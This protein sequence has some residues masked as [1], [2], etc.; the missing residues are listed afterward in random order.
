MLTGGELGTVAL[1]DL[2]PMR[3]SERGRG[4]EIQEGLIASHLVLCLWILVREY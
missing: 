2:H 4:K 1:S 3:S